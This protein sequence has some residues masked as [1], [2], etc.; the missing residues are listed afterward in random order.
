MFEWYVKYRVKDTGEAGDIR[1]I[2][3]KLVQNVFA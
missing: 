3:G 2:E 1:E